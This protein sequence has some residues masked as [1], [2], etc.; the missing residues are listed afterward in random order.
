MDKVKIFDTTLRD[1]EQAPGA[2]LNTEE[3]I[4]IARNLDNLGVD[5]IEAGFAASSPDDSNAILEIGKVVKKAQVC[6]LARA[7]ERDI[8]LAGEALKK[9]KNPRLHTFISTSEIHMKYQIKKT[10]QEVIDIT[11]KSVALARNYCDDVEFSAMDA[12]RSEMDFLLKV[13]ETAVKNGAKTLNI[14]DTVGYMLPWVFADFVKK[15]VD[16]FKDTDVVISVH[17]HDDLGLASANSLSAVTAGARQIECAVN[18][19][20]ER[21]GNTPLEE[22]VM[23][24]KTRKDIFGIDTNINT[25]KLVK[26]SKLVSN[27]TGFPVPPNKAIVGRNAF[28]HEAGIHQD[29]ILKHRETYEI[30]SAEDVGWQT[31]TLVLGKHSGRAALKDRYKDLGFELNEEEIVKIFQRF[32]DLADRKKEIYDEDLE[33]I[34]EDERGK[35]GQKY[36][37]D[38]L[39]VST[40]NKMIPTATIRLMENGEKELIGVANGTGPVD[41]LCNA[42]SKIT[43][44]KN[45][46]TEFSVKAV[47]AGIDAVAEVTIKIE[48]EGRT[49]TGYGAAEDIV[50]ASAKA[51]LNALNRSIRQRKK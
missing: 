7:V 41:A 25:K 20:G 3:K 39:Q 44:E 37:L 34:L 9:S 28:A 35:I 50:F 6:S 49:Y 16:H 29:G 1:G 42:I 33:A 15:V 14:A 47:T 36:E 23:A 2:S 27:L 32:K 21:A 17:C 22:V 5:I 12:T 19:L 11:A 38:L 51:Y 18:G 46:L 45:R 24:M 40:G 8:K 4:R 31:N 43:G 26:T 30:M 10:E 13:F 48:K